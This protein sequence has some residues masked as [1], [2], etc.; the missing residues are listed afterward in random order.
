MKIELEIP[1]WIIK[2]M[3]AEIYEYGA[4]EEKDLWKDNGEIDFNSESFKIAVAQELS[5]SYFSKD[6]HLDIINFLHKFEKRKYP[7]KIK[8]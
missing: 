3:V 1:E 7:A 4:Y 5:S 6:L 8:K 2:N